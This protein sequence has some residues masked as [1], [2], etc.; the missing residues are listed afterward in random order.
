MSHKKDRFRY[1]RVQCDLDHEIKLDASDKQS[2]KELE[3]IGQELYKEHGE[4][5]RFFIGEKVEKYKH[6]SQ[7]IKK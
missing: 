4:E 3:N 1:V 7:I 2:L 5:M 6:C